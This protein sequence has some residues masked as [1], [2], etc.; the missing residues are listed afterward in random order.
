VVRIISISD[1]VY[2]QLSSIKQGRSFTMVIKSLLA[3]RQSKKGEMKELEKFFGVLSKEE[4]DKLRKASA[5]FRKNF[6]AREFKSG[7]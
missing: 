6:K 4:A 3:E 2:M 1:E 5:E 7:V